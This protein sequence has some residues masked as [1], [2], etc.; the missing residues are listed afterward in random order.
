MQQRGLGP[1]VQ[2]GDES[3]ANFM[4]NMREC[5]QIQAASTRGPQLVVEDG[6]GAQTELGGSNRC[7]YRRYLAAKLI[8]QLYML[9][10]LQS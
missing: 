8:H 5:G 4:K 6:T 2:D 10:F 7:A 1:V 3:I 9:R